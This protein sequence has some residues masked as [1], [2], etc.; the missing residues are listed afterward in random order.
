MRII[1]KIAL[2][3]F[4]DKKVLMVRSHTQ[5]DVF[6]SLGGKL[7]KDESEIECLK[8]EIKEEVGCEIEEK[9]LK[10]LVELE[11]IA[12]GKE[13][14]LLNLKLYKGKLI[15][16]VK[17]SSEIVEIAYFDT[18]VDKKHLSIFAKRTLFPWLKKQG[19]IN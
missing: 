8:R 13:E 4:Q 3:V 17:P 14:S 7:E 12:H 11:D 18:S 15:G 1:K 16:E 5:D 9:S 19:Y 6:Y 10:Y 2:A